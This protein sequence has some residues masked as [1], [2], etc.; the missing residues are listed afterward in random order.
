MSAYTPSLAITTERTHDTFIVDIP[1]NV[2]LT[3]FIVLLLITLL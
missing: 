3:L 2:A 1:D